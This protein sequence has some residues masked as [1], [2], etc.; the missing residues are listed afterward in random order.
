[1]PK[2]PPSANRRQCRIS[3]RLLDKTG[4]ISIPFLWS[5]VFLLIFIKSHRNSGKFYKTLSGSSPIFALS[6]HT[7]FGQTQT[8]AT[9]PLTSAIRCK[10]LS[11]SMYTKEYSIILEGKAIVIVI[12]AI[13][14]AVLCRVWPMARGKEMTPAVQNK[15]IY[16]RLIWWLLWRRHATFT[17]KI[18]LFFV[19]YLD[20]V[21]FSGTGYEPES[22]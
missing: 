14:K 21:V 4:K 16:I 15:F 6:I 18:A 12:E 19:V 20:V 8:G 5:A 2:F 11:Q 9:V 22:I 7:T 3:Q 13:Q 10:I 1:M 17:Y